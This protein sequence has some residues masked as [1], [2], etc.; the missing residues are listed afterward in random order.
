MAAIGSTTQDMAHPLSTA[1]FSPGSDCAKRIA[2]L[3]GVRA[4]LTTVPC[5]E[6]VL[7]ETPRRVLEA[8]AEMTRGYKFSPAEI[9]GCHFPAPGDDLIILKDIEF[10]SLCEH[11]LMP[12]TGLAHVG[13]VPD[14]Y[15]VGLSKLARLVDL[16]A[17]RLQMQERLTAEI[18]TAIL[19][20]VSDTGAACV[21]EA[22][23][24]CL[25]YRGAR[26]QRSTFV[27]SSMLGAFRDDA[28]LR[29]E[30]FAAI[31]LTHSRV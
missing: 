31:H 1:D 10:T 22:T 16:F 27:T 23:H 6:A 19:G 3:D 13:Y 4:L 5:T 20:H 7:E 8:F 2:A 18:A 14:G 30:F 12:F 11:H 28:Q 26:K 24:G 17:A 21:I 29:Q 9:L 15:V 25:C